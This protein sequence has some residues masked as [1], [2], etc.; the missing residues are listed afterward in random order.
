MEIGALPGGRIAA[1]MMEYLACECTFFAPV[2]DDDAIMAAYRRA[3]EEG[4]AEGFVPILVKADKLL[5]EWLSMNARP[6]GAD[7]DNCFFDPKRVAEFRR[8]AL[9]LP[10]EE[11]STLFER[12]RG[13]RREPPQ[14]APGMEGGEVNDC[15]AGYWDV[16]SGMTA[17]LILAKVPVKGPWEVFAYLP[18]GGWN[19]CPDTVRLMTTAK[20]WFEQYGAVPAV[21][22]HDTLE[23]D[24]PSPVSRENALE[25]AAEQYSF[26]SDVDEGSGWH[27]GVLADTLCRSTVWHFWWD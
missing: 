24:L 12:M 6:A 20:Y 18:F 14:E 2:K 15:F 26:C 3:R 11:G 9:A 7:R 13:W 5:W 1:A 27:L 19:S 23:F 25:L 17:P 16:F 22:S 10:L 8:Q 21:I 4:P